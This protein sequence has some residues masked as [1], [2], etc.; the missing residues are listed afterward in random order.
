MEEEMEEEKS[1]S[2]EPSAQEDS[3]EDSAKELEEKVEDL[4]NRWK[5][6]AA[7]Y[8]NLERR[9]GKERQEWIKLAVLPIL[10]RLLS[11]LDNLLRARVHF[12]DKGLD[13]ICADLVNILAD[14]GLSEIPVA[15]GDRFDP[16]V[17]ECVELVKGEAGEQIVEVI[18]KGYIMGDRVIRPARV[19]V[20]QKD[21]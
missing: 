10:V 9:V 5:R 13:I 1:E 2:S 21:P 11:V 3:G 20:S 4:T 19:R 14:Q 7:D 8:Q 12:P 16:E 18:D 15:L 6:A 17:H